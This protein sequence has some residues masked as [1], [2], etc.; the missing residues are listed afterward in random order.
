MTTSREHCSSTG[1][2][3]ESTF[4]SSAFQVGVETRIHLDREAS[5]Q[6]V[7]NIHQKTAE[8]LFVFFNICKSIYVNWHPKNMGNLGVIHGY[9][10]TYEP[11]S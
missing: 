10:T 1:E 6:I 8:R 9:C 5:Q 7:F 3:R 2:V 4:P 11:W